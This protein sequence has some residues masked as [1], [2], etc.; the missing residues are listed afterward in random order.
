VHA[1]GGGEALNSYHYVSGNLLQ[2]VDP[3]GLCPAGITG[4]ACS[5]YNEG[6]AML[7]A[8]PTDPTAIE[9]DRL[10]H[11]PGPVR[12][13]IDGAARGDIIEE[14][15]GWNILGQTLAG[16]TPFG[17]AGDWRD[18]VACANRGDLF[19]TGTSA[20]AMVPG[21][22]DLAAA[23]LRTSIRTGLQTAGAGIARATR[24]SIVLLGEYGPLSRFIARFLGS[25]A[26]EAHHLLQDA[27]F[28]FRGGNPG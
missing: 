27:A 13:T 26:P 19:C 12:D 16:F 8:S 14:P 7:G 17:V 21:V 23:A 15:N 6:L 2:A 4:D 24:S 9:A 22:G 25:N 18:I 11:I 3:L 10:S 1:A 28:G 5:A 20:V